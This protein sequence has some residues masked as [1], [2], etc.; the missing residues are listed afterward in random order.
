MIGYDRLEKLLVKDEM[1]SDGR[2][3][4]EVWKSTSSPTPFTTFSH[5]DEIT[6]SNWSQLLFNN[7][8]N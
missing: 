4:L 7:N 6:R 2:Y 5:R 3:V 1:E 8:K